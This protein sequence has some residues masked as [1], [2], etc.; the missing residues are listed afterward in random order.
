MKKHPWGEFLKWRYRALKWCKEEFE[1]S[2][3]ELASKFSMDEMQ[4]TLILMSTDHPLYKE[5]EE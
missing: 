5:D 1:D 3:K 2:D 4:V